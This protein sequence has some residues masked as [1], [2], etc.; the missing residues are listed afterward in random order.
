MLG[1]HA[2]SMQNKPCFNEGTQ[3]YENFHIYS[4]LYFKKP[5]NKYS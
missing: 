3:M 2:K 1:L 5:K 4:S